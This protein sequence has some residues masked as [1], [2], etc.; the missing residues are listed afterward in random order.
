MIVKRFIPIPQ[1]IVYE[2]M[3]AQSAIL[4]K[5]KPVMLNFQSAFSFSRETML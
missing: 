1:E 3:E 5:S 4:S 2:L